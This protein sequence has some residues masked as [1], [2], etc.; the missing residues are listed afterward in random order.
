[1][2]FK[3][4]RLAE[5]YNI[6]SAASEEFDTDTSDTLI[7]SYSK[8]NH[9]Y[10]LGRFTLQF[11]NRPLAD[12]VADLRAMFRKTGG[13]AHSF[14]HKDHADFSTNGG[15]GT[16]TSH[17][18]LCTEID[19]GD[20]TY[21]ITYWFEDDPDET[22]TRR[23]ILLPLASTVR[24]AKLNGVTWTEL[25]ETTHYTVDY[26]TGVITLVSALG[27]G[28]T[29]YAG[30]EFDIPVKFETNLEGVKWSEYEILSTQINLI[31]VRSLDA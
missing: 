8:L 27:M 12:Y 11:D 23:L 25:T 24:V 2:T 1:M 7:N 21:Q 16:P 26:L 13:R 19:A 30:C 15:T 20:K 6:D 10:V 29:L 4:E 31:E 17:D 28:D 9:P 5:N 14:R 22:T 18:Q 3:N